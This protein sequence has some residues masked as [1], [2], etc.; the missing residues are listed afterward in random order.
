MK[1]DKTIASEKKINS[2]NISEIPHLN[3]NKPIEIK[4][5]NLEDPNCKNTDFFH[6][7]LNRRY[8]H[9]NG[10]MQLSE[11]EH[12]NKSKKENK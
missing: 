7:I 10:P 11:Y 9:Q 6:H 1:E 3:V 2:P 4:D 12:K 8:E 5:D